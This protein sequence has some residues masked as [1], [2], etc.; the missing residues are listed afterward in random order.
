MKLIN[1]ITMWFLGVI[2]LV[3]PVTMFISRNN[4]KKH[5]DQ[6]EISRM[7]GV[8]DHVYKQLL[9]GG[10]PDHY[11]HGRPI[12]VSLYQGA[13]P[14]QKVQVRKE[15]LAEDDMVKKE[16]RITVDSYYPIGDQIY[17]IS[18]YNFVLNSQDIFDGMLYTVVWKML[19]MVLGVG[20]TA[21]FLSRI[22]LEP[23]YRAMKAIKEF[24]LKRGDSKLKL[25]HTTTKEFQEL[26]AFL[27]K[28]TDKAAADYASV[29]EFSENASHELQTPLAIVRSKLDL[30][31]QTQIDDRQ[32]TLIGDMQSAIERLSHINRS[33][34]LLT[35]LENQEYK[36]AE[37]IKFCKV[38]RNV[39]DTYEDWIKMKEIRLHSN[40]DK[41]VTLQIHPVLAEILIGNLLSNAIRYNDEGGQIRID[42]T[43]QWLRISNTGHPPDLPTADMFSRFKKGNQCNESTGLGLA[44][45]KQI[46]DVNDFSVTYQFEKGWHQVKVQ[47]RQAEL[48]TVEGSGD[49]SREGQL[50]VS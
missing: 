17:K 22:I 3:T 1:K 43:R 23:F 32:A 11:T 45:V 5:L 6:A 42:L 25:P 48:P 21:R 8:N 4:I 19:I 36:T 47:F 15:N 9:A 37:S 31:S 50:A 16:C 44:I 28:M 20:L 10:K 26:N 13:M 34:V 41:N 14:Q 49:M 29:K 12:E 33:L 30:L 7:T 2:L 27:R 18:S 39:M 46:C 35:K 40:L 24:D 38:T